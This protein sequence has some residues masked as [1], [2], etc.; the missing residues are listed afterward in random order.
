MTCH[1]TTF[2]LHLSYNQHSEFSFIHQQTQVPDF[3]N[4]PKIAKLKDNNKQE[5]FTIKFS[6][7]VLLLERG[8]NYIML[9][10]RQIKNDREEREKERRIGGDISF[11][12]VIE[13]L[14]A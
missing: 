8:N 12:Y 4:I 6:E 5:N 11:S 10:T 14:R 13:I 2:N 7:T 3:I 9:F 1:L